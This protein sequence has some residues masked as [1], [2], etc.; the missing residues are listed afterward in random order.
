[1]DLF[2]AERIVSGSQGL[3]YDSS[4]SAHAGPEW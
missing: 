2:D 3:T 4:D 1:L